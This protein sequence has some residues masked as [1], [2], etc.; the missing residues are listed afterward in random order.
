MD[1]AGRA[2]RRR[3]LGWLAAALGAIAGAALTLSAPALAWDH[4]THRLIAR[5]ALG[6]LPPSPLKEFLDRN[7]SRLEW[8]TVE[9][10]RIPGRAEKRRHYIDLETYG[11]HPFEA[12]DPDRA[13]ME[14]EWGRARFER[15]GT[16]PWTIESRAGE[17]GRAWQNGDCAG[18][19]K[20]SGYVA[21][22]VGDASQPLHT[23]V[24]YDGYRDYYGDRGMHSRLEGAADRDVA[25]LAAIAGPQVRPVP[26]SSVWSAAIEEI[27]DAHKLVGYVVTA[28]RE[29]RATLPPRSPEFDRRLIALEQG[30]AASQIARASSVLASI[31]LY[32]WERAGRP[33]S[34]ASGPR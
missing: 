24:H 6:A 22:Y 20:L 25:A 1:G 23:T 9:P 5:L 19:L 11:R 33:A 34:C 32:E 26:L 16:L 13:A 8:F 28:D 18:V 15:N 4:E 30:M 14:R 21:H 17:L 2:R 7:E 12:L 3:R 27:G 10:D 29:T 31:W